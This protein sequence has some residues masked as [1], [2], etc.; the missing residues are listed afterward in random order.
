MIYKRPVDGSGSWTRL[1]GAL[2][3]V[4][5]SGN[6]Y[7]WGV[8]SNDDIYKCKKPCNG[9]W[10]KVDG[11]L[12]Q[13]DG[14]EAYVYGVNR[15]DDI[16]TR[17]VDGSGRWRQIPGKLRHITASGKDEVFGTNA[18]GEVFRCKKPCVGEWEKIESKNLN[19]CDGTFN[20]L[21]GVDESNG[22]FSREIGI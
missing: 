20:L 12:K 21:V 9:L 7:I 19:Q 8:N 3:H 5:A 15:N 17:P 4:S 2:K 18:N 14:G 11:K 6:G 22:I 1:P 13:I 16:Y 10:I